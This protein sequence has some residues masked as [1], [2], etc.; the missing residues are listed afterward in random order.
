MG[1][2]K[3][4]KKIAKFSVI[5]FEKVLFGGIG[6]P[7]KVGVTPEELLANTVLPPQPTLQRLGISGQTTFSRLTQR[8]L[9][10]KSLG[11]ILS[12]FQLPF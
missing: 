7:G 3:K 4:F 9:G 5:P 10:I 2:F 1:L 12:P 11:T 8:R 6:G